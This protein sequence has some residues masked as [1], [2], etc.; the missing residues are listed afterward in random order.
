MWRAVWE[1][2]WVPVGTFLLPLWLPTWC[3]DFL[4]PHCPGLLFADSSTFL[5][6][7]GWWAQGWLYPTWPDLEL[8]SGVLIYSPRA[9][10]S[11][12]GVTD[13]R[14]A[15]S[16]PVSTWSAW[17]IHSFTGPSIRSSNAHRF[18]VCS[19][20]EPCTR[21][22][23]C[24]PGVSRRVWMIDEKVTSALHKLCP[25]LSQ[26]IPGGSPGQG[27]LTEGLKCGFLKINFY[28][29]IVAF[30]FPDGS[31]VKNPSVMQEMW[32]LSLSQKD[33]LEKEMATHSS[34]LAWE[35]PWTEDPGGLQTVHRATKELDMT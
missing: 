13:T 10:L 3:P 8:V 11:L 29:S 12:S 16:C 20:L 28:W 25:G 18:S 19:L 27:V 21:H 15:H 31:V 4:W 5:P 30:G 23:L 9:P 35:I 24:L 2:W 22:S 26:A 6:W 7:L 17:R 33:A 32:V 34:I 14:N 1:L